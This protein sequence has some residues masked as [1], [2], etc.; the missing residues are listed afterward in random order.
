MTEW[1]S[2]EKNRVRGIRGVKMKKEPKKVPMP[3]VY[4]AYKMCYVCGTDN[5]G[6]LHFENR[7][8]G[9][10]GI[11]EFRPKPFM[12]GLN[13]EE[14][15]LMHGGF[16]MMMFDEIMLYSIRFLLDLDAVSLNINTNFVSPAI[17]DADYRVETVVKERDGRKIW[18]DA[19]MKANGKVVARAT[20][21]YYVVDMDK[22]VDTGSGDL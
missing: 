20:G 10:K 7:I 9:D 14:N 1:L 5:R 11:L 17:M 21:L 18:M 12:I 22:F 19:E 2:G 3:E 13:S 4:K 8:E 16:T 15:Q 6:G